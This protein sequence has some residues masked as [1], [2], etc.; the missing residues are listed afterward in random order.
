MNELA[1]TV[2]QAGQLIIGAMNAA[3]VAQSGKDN[4]AA[5]EAANRGNME[6]AKY[7]FEQNL[8]QWNRQN[9]YNTPMAQMQRF[10]DAGLNPNL[11][12]GQGSNGNA[13]SSPEYKAPHLQA[14]TGRTRD[15]QM[16][17]Q[18]SMLALEMQQ[19]QLQND[20]IAAGIEQTR[21]QTENTIAQTQ[22][23]YVNTSY[24]KAQTE[25]FVATMAP[26]ERQE[27]A[28]A[29]GLEYD[30]SINQVSAA[31]AMSEDYGLMA[32]AREN[33][34]LISNHADKLAKEWDYIKTQTDILDI[35][36]KYADELEALGVK[37]ASKRIEMVTQQ[38]VNLIKEGKLKDLDA[39]IQGY[40]AGQAAQGINPKLSPEWMMAID[41]LAGVL[42]KDSLSP[43]AIG[44]GF[45]DLFFNA[46]PSL[47]P[48]GFFNKPLY[49][50]ISPLMSLGTF[51]FSRLARPFI[52]YGSRL[53]TP[54]IKVK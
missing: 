37:E 54:T 31:V 50:S 39:I 48:S 21:A 29:L 11:I 5:V 36:K 45:H 17:A 3:N 32:Q 24:T 30:A 16:L 46:N 2:N 25:Y 52:S 40:F 4:I 28:K 47:S 12:F 18:T 27:L 19:K 34:R 22:G 1:N 14:Y 53:Y 13:S 15:A 23:T 33:L 9:A 38:I 26:R 8:E 43:N 10:K 44:R 51:G 35:K 7:Q 49:Q 41:L 6:L 20:A 42:G